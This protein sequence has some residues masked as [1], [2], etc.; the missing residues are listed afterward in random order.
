MP[1]AHEQ[2]TADALT[3]IR[4]KL[5]M[6]IEQWSPKLIDHESR[7]RKLEARVWVAAGAAAAGAGTLGSVV[8]QFL[9][10]PGHRANAKRPA[11]PR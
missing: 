4:V 3:E 1:P 10:K 7:L 9:G 5:D 11:Q 2:T 6:L 8:S